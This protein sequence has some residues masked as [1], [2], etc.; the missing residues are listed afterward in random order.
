MTEASDISVLYSDMSGPINVQF[1]Q[2]YYCDMIST[3]DYA[4]FYTSSSNLL[5]IDNYFRDNGRFAN[6]MTFNHF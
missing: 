1:A 3:N 2:N 5:I 4:L 6:F